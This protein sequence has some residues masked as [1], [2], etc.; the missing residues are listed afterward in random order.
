MTEGEKLSATNLDSSDHVQLQRG[1]SLVG[2]L[3][4][5][6]GCPLPPRAL[7]ERGALLQ[8]GRCANLGELARQELAQDDS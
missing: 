3:A 4:Y 5:S 6:L 8:K 7:S 1:A 2:W